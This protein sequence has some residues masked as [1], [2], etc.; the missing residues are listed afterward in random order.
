MLFRSIL[1]WGI[2]LSLTWDEFRRVKK[3]PRVVLIAMLVQLVAVPC[4][5]IFLN[6]LFQL[7]QPLAIGLLLLASMPG[8]TTANVFSFISK[9]NVALN[10]TLTA[11]NSVLGIFTVPLMVYLS[12]LIYQ[13]QG[14]AI[15]LQFSKLAQVLFIL[16][17]PMLLGMLTRNKFPKFAVSSEKHILKFTFFALILL[18]IVGVG[19]EQEL[20]LNHIA[21]AGPVV[22]LLNLGSLGLAYLTSRYLVLNRADTSA[23]IMELGIHNCALAIGI[24]M[25]PNLLNNITIA[26]PAVIYI[27]LMYLTAL[28]IALW[29]RRRASPV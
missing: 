7:P 19:N 25:S 1:I 8:G 10:I 9:G 3:N 17:V 6:W 13:D 11:I 5:A 24:G 14:T 23:L 16:I 15:P 27:V 4:L 29:F 20:I 22:L 2:G 18:L 26:V 21:K 12:F 28:P